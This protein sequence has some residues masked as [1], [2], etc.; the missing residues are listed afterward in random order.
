MIHHN[1]VLVHLE[2][3]IIHLNDVL[4]HSEIIMVLLSNVLYYPNIKM[5]GFNN[6]LDHS[7]FRTARCNDVFDHSKIKMT[8]CFDAMRHSDAI[9]ML[10][11]ESK[12][13]ICKTSMLNLIIDA[14]VRSTLPLKH[15]ITM[16]NLPILD[17]C[18]DFYRQS[19][20]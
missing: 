10:Y 19:G 14:H 20:A 2:I 6:V 13:Y 15:P 7:N 16:G 12:T 11:I 17:R 3:R 18:A 1:H 4:N 9:L 8:K 5:T